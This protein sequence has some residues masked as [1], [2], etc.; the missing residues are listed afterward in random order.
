MVGC[1]GKPCMTWLST[2]CAICECEASHGYL[3]VSPL[4]PAEL[5]FDSSTRPYFNVLTFQHK[6]YV[7]KMQIIFMLVLLSH[8][9]QLSSLPIT[10]NKGN[11]ERTRFLPFHRLRTSH[12]YTSCYM[13]QS[14]SQITLAIS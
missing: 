14:Q 4:V 3:F 9:S 10:C 11:Y 1:W 12:V 13:P 6:K 2:F 5:S 7:K 8:D